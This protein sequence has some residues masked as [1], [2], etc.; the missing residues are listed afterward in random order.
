MWNLDGN[1]WTWLCHERGVKLWILRNTVREAQGENVPVVL[2]CECEIWTLFRLHKRIMEAASSST[3]NWLNWFRDS[4]P[5]M[6]N[7]RA[8]GN[9]AKRSVVLISTGPQPITSQW[10]ID[11]DQGSDNN[12]TFRSENIV[13]VLDLLR[14]VALGGFSKHF[15]IPEHEKIFISRVTCKQQPMRTRCVSWLPSNIT[16]AGDVTGL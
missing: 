4:R 12:L 3:L 9:W 13:F 1:M 15:L 2:V 16:Q 6:S 5:L 7:G 14:S 11:P 8:Q 10:A